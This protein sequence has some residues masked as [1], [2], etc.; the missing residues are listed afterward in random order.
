M[1]FA[2]D[3]F[4]KER[5]G[6]ITG[7]RCSVLFPKK[8]GKVGQDTY[9]RQLANQMF[10]QT[11]DEVSTWQME[12]GKMAQHFALAHYRE[13][14]DERIEP[15]DWRRKGSCGGTTD[16]EIPKIKGVDF[17]CPTTLEQWLDYLYDG[18]DWQ[19]ENQCRMYMYLADL[20][21]WEIAAYLTETQKMSDNGLTYPVPEEKRMIRISVQRNLE[22]E[23][24][25]L[26]VVPSV[27]E[28]RDQYIE[29]LKAHFKPF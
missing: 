14:I 19:Q 24:A 21:E 17:K 8:G 5:L 1:E 3:T 2:I 13:R 9:A 7:S 26:L 16:A 22:W 10:W 4:N 28:I 23:K 15:G 12:H 6:L 11:Y 27:I 20:P 25:L 18:M 29:K